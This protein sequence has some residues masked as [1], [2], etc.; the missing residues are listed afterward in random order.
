MW[1]HGGGAHLAPSTAAVAAVVF[2]AARTMAAAAAA[3]AAEGGAIPG[4]DLLWWVQVS[5]LHVGSA[6][7]A[8]AARAADLE[9][10]LG[11]ALAVI[12]PA[13]VLLTGDLTDARGKGMGTPRQDEAEWLRY[14]TAV[15]RL[16]TA[17][18]LPEQLMLDLRGNHD[19]YGVPER[20]GPCDYFARDSC[21]A[22]WHNGSEVYSVTLESGAGRL[23]HFVGLDSAPSIGIRPP[24]NFF[25]H[26]EDR[27]LDLLQMELAA[28]TELGNAPAP[29]E[30]RNMTTLVFAHYPLA[31][32]AATPQGR[33]LVDTVAEGGNIAGFVSGHLHTKFGT[34]LFQLHRRRGGTVWEWVAGD[35]KDS[36]AVRVMAADGG[37]ASF[38]DIRLL[39]R[40]RSAKWQ[41]IAAW[42]WWVLHWWRSSEPAQAVDSFKRTDAMEEGGIILVTSPPDCRFHDVTIGRA[43]NVVNVRALVFSKHGHL[44]VVATVHADAGAAPAPAPLASQ[45]LASSNSGGD[46]KGP[47]YVGAMVLPIQEA[48]KLDNE[49]ILYLI[50]TATDSRNATFAAEP[51]ALRW[52]GRGGSGGNSVKRKCRLVQTWVE[53]AMVGTDWEAAWPLACRGAFGV[54]LA[55]T[56]LPWVLLVLLRSLDAHDRFTSWLLDNQSLP[57]LPAALLLWALVESAS[58]DAV[59]AGQLLYVSYL[60]VLPWFWGRFLGNGHPVGHLSIWGISL[61]DSSNHSN[62]L[63]I[64]DILTV[65]VPWLYGAVLP[66]AYWLVALAAERGLAR[67]WLRPLESCRKQEGGHGHSPTTGQV[68]RRSGSNGGLVADIGQRRRATAVAAAAAS[69]SNSADQKLDD[70]V[71]TR[72]RATR[73]ERSRA[74]LRLLRLAL[75]LSALAILAFVLQ[76][77]KGL[78][79]AYGWSAV[80][81]SPG[82]AWLLAYL[83]LAAAWKLSL[84]S[85]L[86]K[87]FGSVAC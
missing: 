27:H 19:T 37:L 23:H 78:A 22:R 71:K 18:S 81:A 44:R 30:R 12:R 82:V 20:R 49:A 60:A 58:D 63:F 42:S 46:G 80:I 74:T 26:P 59:V 65:T 67:R 76:Q 48:Q 87:A 31:F 29:G 5:D 8:A 40:I 69:D 32:T 16:A 10:H 83:A 77:V 38:V 61:S 7:P 1:R 34:Q 84:S 55:T 75:C 21:A 43:S 41:S 35:W 51:R 62:G 50:V 13:L 86:G 57:L 6:S 56:L 70:V 53:R 79:Q 68:I 64:P 72:L 28:G 73:M 24:A 14:R 45:E 47:L 3:A 17:C 15:A 11:P 25:G 66:S 36:R 85:T 2:M 4:E 9:A 54:L 52:A 33:S 39:Q